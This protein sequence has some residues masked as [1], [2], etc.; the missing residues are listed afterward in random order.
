MRKNRVRELIRAGKPT[1]STRM[2]TTSPQIVEMIGHTGVID[3]IELMADYASWTVTDLENFARAV[4]LFPHMSSMIKVE[5]DP[6]LFITQRALG[7]GIQNI[8]FADCDTAEEVKQCI[9]LVRP[10]L[11][12]D[13]GLHGCSARRASDYTLNNGSQE[14]IQA[15]RDVVI[16]FMIESASAMEQL[17]DILSVPGVDMVHFGPCDFCLTSG[18]PYERTNPDLRIKNRMVMEKALKHGVR[19]RAIVG[20][21]EQAKEFADMGVLDFCFGTDLDIIH[22]F[23]KSNGSKMREFFAKK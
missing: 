8:L 1:I 22:S 20:S 14:W 4:E 18:Y 3:F 10:V 17:D 11:P 7:A 21:F 12:Q 9:R 2:L 19:P 23:C 5:E 13:G 15:Q 16:E 6:R